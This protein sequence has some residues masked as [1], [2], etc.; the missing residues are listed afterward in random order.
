M[1]SWLAHPCS[2]AV[3][4]ATTSTRSHGG[5]GGIH[6]IGGYKGYEPALIWT[7]LFKFPDHVEHVSSLTCHG[8][9][10]RKGCH[11][12]PYLC[13][14]RRHQ[15]L[16]AIRSIFGHAPI[17]LYKQSVIGGLTFLAIKGHSSNSE[18]EKSPLSLKDRCRYYVP[19]VPNLR[20]LLR[21]SQVLSLQLLESVVVHV[22]P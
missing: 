10:P 17:M 21:W 18:R 1:L 19:A 6:S 13:R 16:F 12:F 20:P 15:V 3:V 22:R 2:H 5:E 11:I 8:M 4:Y 9:T 7:R 14:W